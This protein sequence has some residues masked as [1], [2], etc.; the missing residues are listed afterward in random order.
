MITLPDRIKNDLS[1]NLTSA[2]YLVAIKT[3]PVIYISTTKQMFDA[4]E[5]DVYGGANLIE[6]SYNSDFN[7]VGS[8]WYGHGG[9]TIT[10]GSDYGAN[11]SG[12]LMIEPDG[13]GNEGAGLQTA[14]YEGE[15]KNKKF[16]RCY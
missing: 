8:N 14:Y 15:E 13:D 10:W 3:D 16:N 2:E 9:A 1:G 7:T 6:E 4:T 11:D 5:G 12:G